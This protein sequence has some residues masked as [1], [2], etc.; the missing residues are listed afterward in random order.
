ML[1][2]ILLIIAAA[3]LAV[4]ALIG[5]SFF[6]SSVREG[7]RRASV[8]AGF[9]FL[10]ML[11]VFALFLVL[12]SLGIFRTGPGLFLLIL[13]YAAS[14]AGAFLLLRRTAPNPRALRGAAGR[15]EGKVTRFD[16]RTQ[17]FARNRSLRPGAD[18]YHRFYQEHPEFQEFDLR[19]R[20]K[21][22][23]IGHPGVIDRPHEEANVAMMLASQSMCM[24]LSTPEKTDPQPHFY[25]REKVSGRRVALDPAEATRRVKGYARHL[26]AALV[27]V[28][29][30][31]P[32]WI[33]SHRGEIFHENWEDWGKEI[34]LDHNYAIVLA[35]EMSLEM[36]GSGPHTPTTVES[37]NNYAKGAYI[38]AQIAAFIANLGYSATANHLRHYDSLMVPLAVDAGLGELGRLGYLMTRE[39][40]PRVRLSAVTTDLP[41]V[42]DKPVDIGVEDFCEICKKCSVCCP[43]GSIP[44]GNQTVVNGTLRWKLNDQTCFEYWGKVGTDCNVCMRVCPWSHARTFPHRIIVALITRNRSARRIFSAMDDLFYGRRPKSKVPPRWVQFNGKEVK[45]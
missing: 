8:F 28:A 19:R 11:L 26:G 42:S 21:G 35:E 16:E 25:L 33:Y 30:I 23:P 18:E 12:A 39:Y 7:E 44:M 40:G 38:S 41:L 5:L 1:I 2:S 9:Q 4:Q 22:G 37:M 10:G 3:G 34:R 13:G 29:E 45:A 27:G 6:I 31:N 24:Y 14:G 20:R 17:V 36:I 15:M 43:S 32:L